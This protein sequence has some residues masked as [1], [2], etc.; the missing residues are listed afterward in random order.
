MPKFSEIYNI[1][2]A[3]AELDFVDISVETDT[4]LYVDP[5]A[6]TTR[7]DNW[8][9][10]CHEQVVS[11]FQ[12][13]LLSVKNKDS[14]T[15]IQLLSHLNEPEETHL[16]VS[17]EGNSGR[18]IGGQQASDLYEAL[19]RS[20]AAST[21]LLEDVSDF[22]L[23]I[24]GIGR[25]KISDITTNVIRQSLI[26]YTQA[27]CK[28]YNIP[29]RSVGSGFFW[30][31]NTKTWQQGYVELPV[32]DMEKLL[33][34][35]K[36]MVRYR[37]GVDHTRYRKMFVL[38]FLKDEH[39]R[40]D[41]SLVTTIRNKRTGDIRKKVVYK[42]TVDEHYPT[43]KDFLTD[44]SLAHPEV[45]DRYRDTLKDIASKIPD[46]NDENYKEALLAKK[47]KEELLAIPTG[48]ASANEYHDY[49]LSVISFLF[50]PNL[51]YPKKE[52]EINDGRKR[53]DITYTNGKIS[54]LFYRIAIDQHLKGNTIHVECKNYT[55]DVNNPE[56]DQLL[57]R[58]DHN[59]G[60]FGMLFFR[61][62]DDM[63]RL[64]SRCKDAAGQSLG[65]ALPID[66]NFIFKCLEYVENNERRK[67]DAH[68]EALFQNVIS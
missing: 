6:L 19:S 26:E 55:K 38:E 43:D 54:G 32:H 57:G 59:R 22:A 64:I 13:V 42:K 41:D 44:F 68:L 31:V 63:N 9:I 16:G 66:D 39:L 30:D 27:Q 4:P 37:V 52:R 21:G 28:L 53:I 40:A 33:L 12:S 50:F 65:V 5:Y 17:K 61:N 49:C 1:N 60:R 34:V 24:P 51:I 47:L 2:K 8:S 10:Q 48:A 29:M 58:F 45:I 11:F 15:G 7:D 25:D 18:G 67:I 36:Y 3:Q 20:K 14:R 62:A 35:P 23:F 46:I 56:L